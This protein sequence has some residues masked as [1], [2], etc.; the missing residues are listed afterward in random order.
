MLLKKFLVVCIVAL[1]SALLYLALTVIMDL[2]SIIYDHQLE[3]S[4]YSVSIIVFVFS[5]IGNLVF[6]LPLS[7]LLDYISLKKKFNKLA[8]LSLYILCA[9]MIIVILEVVINIFYY[10]FIDNGTYVIFGILSALLFWF[11]NTILVK[12]RN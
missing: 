8:S 12:P 4:G 7:Y 5:F 1:T 2:K 6:A 10:P 9:I 3:N 11:F